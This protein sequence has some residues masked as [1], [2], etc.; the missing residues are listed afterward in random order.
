MPPF[1][2]HVFICTHE[3]KDSPDTCCA[4]K[5]GEKLQVELKKRLKEQGLDGMIRANK[6]GC[7]DACK[8]GAALVIYPQ[9]IWY[10]GVKESDLDEIINKSLKEDGVIE[11]LVPTQLYHEANRGKSGNG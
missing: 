5:N 8:Y 1:N 2:K 11:R 9:G 7:L 10:G 6:A 3:R 4:T